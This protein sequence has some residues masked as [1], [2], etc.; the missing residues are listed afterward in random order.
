MNR[1][2]GCCCS[3]G[4]KAAAA[5]FFFACTIRFSSSRSPS[6]PPFPRSDF[7][8]NFEGFFC[9]HKKTPSRVN[10]WAV[11]STFLRC[12]SSILPWLDVKNTDFMIFW[13]IRWNLIFVL[14]LCPSPRARR[15]LLMSLSA[16]GGRWAEKSS[17][18]RK[19]EFESQLKLN[20]KSSSCWW[21]L[22]R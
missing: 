10:I 19:I 7:M 12:F 11:L 18:L 8:I 14:S 17:S 20:Y 13:S 3:L 5:W 15:A 6:P 9:L 21:R 22:R 2:C 1:G 4:D 16:A